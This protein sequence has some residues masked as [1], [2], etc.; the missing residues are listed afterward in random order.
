[1]APDPETKSLSVD[2]VRQIIEAGRFDELRGVRE[3]GQVEFKAE[4]YALNTDAQKQELAKDITSMANAKGGVIVLGVKTAKRIDVLGDVAV[5]IR[6]F[7]KSLLNADQLAQ[8]VKN[9]IYPGIEVATKWI[10][11]INGA[12]KGLV[13]I[14]VPA[15]HIEL[16]P[17]LV[18]RYVNGE[19]KIDSTV[20]GYY[21]RNEA[22][23]SAMSFQ[24]LHSKIRRG[25]DQSSLGNQI[26]RV[27]QTLER[28]VD[29]LAHIDDGATRDNRTMLVADT[30][31]GERPSI[32]LHAD[33][34][35]ECEEAINAVGFDQ[36]PSIVLA[37]YPST[38]VEMKGLF[39]RSESSLIDTL[40]NSP[41]LR[42]N[43]W[44]LHIDEPFQNIHGRL[45]RQ[46]RDKAKLLQISRDGIIIFVA[47]GNWRFLSYSAN[48][49]DDAAL[50]IQPF[51]LAHV[52]LVFVMHCDAIYEF[53]Q[54]APD[55]INYVLEL[56]NMARGG[57]R[58]L[59]HPNHGRLN[60]WPARSAFKEM[61][62]ESLSFEC[63]FPVKRSP[64]RVTYELVRKV[65]EAFGFD[66]EQVP[67]SRM[68][69]GT[70]VIDEQSLFGG[71]TGP[72]A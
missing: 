60:T 72:T 9:W 31:S 53:A 67:Y 18:T 61:E 20:F 10:S 46:L 24:E 7:E 14:E 32:N 15:G 43:G 36:E 13:I 70:W 65:F 50:L 52:A 1:M 21:V 59:L 47:P 64:G 23:V 66:A 58:A 8:V 68:D 3:T 28:V 55:N 62:A 16:V 22:T 19:G 29:R 2:T 49:D 27:E 37:A 63:T 44:D 12:D 26:D 5:E 40:H 38:K 48:M 11:N 4:V 56:R 42:G 39:A 33:F 69:Q 6:Q 57:K 25:H 30:L 34:N 54:P 51:V 45:R 71:S 35:R 41:K 17:Y